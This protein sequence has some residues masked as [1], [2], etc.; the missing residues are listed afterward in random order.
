MFES[1]D[2]DGSFSRQQFVAGMLSALSVALCR[3]KTE[4]EQTILVYFTL[5]HPGWA[6]MPMWRA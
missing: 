6:F 4:S 2:G 3:W 1:A 5:A